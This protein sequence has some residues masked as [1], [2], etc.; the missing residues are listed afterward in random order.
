MKV[1]PEL[2]R[3]ALRT[4]INGYDPDCTHDELIRY[5]EA[6]FDAAGSI[7]THEYNAG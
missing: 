4:L 2:L 3:E 5:A 1:E 7:L 6:L